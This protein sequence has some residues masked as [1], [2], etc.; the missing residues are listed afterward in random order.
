[1]TFTPS[2]RT[3]LEALCRRLA[4]LP[5]A[6]DP[7]AAALADAVG[8]RLA[9]IDPEQAALVARLLSLLDHPATAALTSGRP[10]R[11]SRMPPAR[12]D[13]WLRS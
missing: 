1:M 4:R 9:T 8:A 3:A 10:T 12:Q 5:E 2:Q 11:F 7:A 6:P 13:A